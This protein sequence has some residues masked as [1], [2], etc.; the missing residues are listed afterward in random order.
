MTWSFGRVEFVECVGCHVLSIFTTASCLFLDKTMEFSTRD[1]LDAITQVKFTVTIGNRC[2]L[3]TIIVIRIIEW[4]GQIKVSTSLGALKNL[5]SEVLVNH[6]RLKTESLWSVDSIRIIIRFGGRVISSLV[7]CEIIKL[8]RVA[9]VE[10][11]KSRQLL[12]NNIPG[13][14]TTGRSHEMCKNGISSKDVTSSINGKFLNNRVISRGD[15][16]EVPVFD[17]LKW[18]STTRR[19]TVVLIIVLVEET[20]PKQIFLRS[21]SNLLSCRNIL[22]K[23]GKIKLIHTLPVRTDRHGCLTIHA[24]LPSTAVSTATSKVCATS[25][26]LRLIVSTTRLSTRF[27]STAGVELTKTLLVSTATASSGCNEALAARCRAWRGVH[28][29]EAAFL[30]VVDLV[31]ELKVLAL[32]FAEATAVAVLMLLL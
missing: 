32:I 23:L 15:R 18:H 6:C 21:G 10:E 2:R 8:T 14:D 1:K 17:P 19:D 12:H 30:L 5:L 3:H 27:I 25:S 28:Q 16:V 20:A 22:G 26:P 24:V 11:K 7:D 13:V 29:L 4:V 31:L 9:L